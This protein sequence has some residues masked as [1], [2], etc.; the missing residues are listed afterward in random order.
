MSNILESSLE[1]CI[2]LERVLTS[3]HSSLIITRHRAVEAWIWITSIV[4]TTVVRFCTWMNPL[5]Y[6]EF[7]APIVRRSIPFPLNAIYLESHRTEVARKWARSTKLGKEE[8]RAAGHR[9]ARRVVRGICP[10]NENGGYWLNSL[11][12]FTFFL[13]RE[14]PGSGSNLRRGR[15][16]SVRSWRSFKRRELSS[17]S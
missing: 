7:T 13:A 3:I 14:H 4:S 6:K 12:D 5:C 10:A 11:N 1:R 15:V 16:P 2:E 9:V 17:T 8:S